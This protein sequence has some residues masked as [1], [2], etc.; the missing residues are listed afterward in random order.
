M[1]QITNELE[2]KIKQY[3]KAE[4]DISELIKDIDLRNA[5]LSHAII[6]NFDVSNQ[7]ISGCRLVY[8]KIQKAKMIKTIAHNVQFNGADMSYSNCSSID[9]RNSNFLDANCMF[10]NFKYA[11]LRGVNVC[12]MTW[13]FSPKYFFK[14][15]VS[16]N[17][18][19]LIARICDIVNDDTQLTFIE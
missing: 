6:N 19:D 14:T 16:S 7:D 2:N 4:K 12:A 5:D 3:I 11:D 8:A 18:T 9:A 13:T 17:I 1:K 15:K 10:T